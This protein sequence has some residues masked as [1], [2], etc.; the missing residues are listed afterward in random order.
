MEMFMEKSNSF[1]QPTVATMCI[2]I[3]MV[4]QLLGRN[5]E[6]I[7][8][9]TRAINIARHVFGYNH[10][11]THKYKDYLNQLRQKL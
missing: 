8:Y 7:E 10:S 3:A 9:T 6:A 5:S 4:F 2:N 11:Q 1:H